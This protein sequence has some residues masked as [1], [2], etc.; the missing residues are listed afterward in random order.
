ML[1]GGNVQGCDRFDAHC[2]DMEV[3]SRKLAEGVDLLLAQ[4]WPCG[5][6]KRPETTQAIGRLLRCRLC[7]RRRWQAAFRRR[8]A[9]VVAEGRTWAERQKEGARLNAVENL[10]RSERLAESPPEGLSFKQLCN[11]VSAA[12]GF[13]VQEVVGLGRRCELVGARSVIIVILKE[14][15]LSFPFIGRLLGDRDHSTIINCAKKFGIYAARDDRVMRAYE[16][17]RDRG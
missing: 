8:V 15:G 13:T 14:R 1:D 7:R 16:R 10:Q 3:G 2:S 17:L 12:F 5:H 6:I 9:R 11:E 4:R